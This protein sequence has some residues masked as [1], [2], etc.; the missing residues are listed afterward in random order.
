MTDRQTDRDSSEDRDE[1]K[2]PIEEG[3]GV[4]H[5]KLLS[6]HGQGRDEDLGSGETAPANY[7]GCDDYSKHASEK[8]NKVRSV[9]KMSACTR[10][11]KPT[12]IAEKKYHRE[13]TG[14]A[15]IIAL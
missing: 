10:T 12:T 7:R 14:V 5:Q 3:T 13:N 6:V 11:T 9:S 1:G 8:V 4:R 15:K 2:H